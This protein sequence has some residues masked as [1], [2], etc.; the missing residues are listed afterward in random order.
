MLK[1]LVGAIFAALQTEHLVTRAIFRGGVAVSTRDTRRPEAV[2]VTRRQ[3]ESPADHILQG[4]ARVPGCLG[5]LPTTFRGGLFFCR[6]A[7][8]SVK[9]VSRTL[10]YSGSFCHEITSSLVSPLCQESAIRGR[11]WSQLFRMVV[12]TTL[13]IKAPEY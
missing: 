3:P 5:C 10:I 12:S 11:S 8:R 4:K 13:I 7:S 6:P 2:N 9:A 1:W